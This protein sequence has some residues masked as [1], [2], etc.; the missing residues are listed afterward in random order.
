MLKVNITTKFIWILFAVTIL[1]ACGDPY[2]KKLND[3]LTPSEAEKI[4]RSLPS[5]DGDL[6]VRW[7][8]R[9]SLGERFGGEG[10]VYTVRDAINTQTEYEA[11]KAAE[12]E[13]EKELKKKQE[14][15]RGKEALEIKEKN[16]QIENIRYL[17]QLTDAEINKAIDKR[18]VN[19]RI[20]PQLDRFNREIGWQWVFNIEVKNKTK[21]PVIGLAGYITIKD[22]FGENLGTY[23]FSFQSEINEGQSKILSLYMQDD[24]KNQNLRKLKSAAKIFPEWFLESLAFSNG[25]RIDLES[26]EKST[27]SN[28]DKGGT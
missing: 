25:W 18:A 21:T 24:P 16:L 11:R 2:A 27:K 14:A 3:K 22:V 26:V 9:N 10:S 7:S 6:F 20:E 15:I 8:K 1:S 12:Y 23:P 13:K 4:A 19:Y 5:S 28:T 17:R